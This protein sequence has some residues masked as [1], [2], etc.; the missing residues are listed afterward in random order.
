MFVNIQYQ[1]IYIF[2]IHYEK[3]FFL[4]NRTFY[5]SLNTSWN[6]NKFLNW[7]VPTHQLT[8]I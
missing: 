7:F 6:F 1:E 8:Q 2:K 5:L 3:V 4:M